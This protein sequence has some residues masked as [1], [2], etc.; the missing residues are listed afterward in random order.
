M[1]GPK[2]KLSSEQEHDLVT[3]YTA[4]ESINA[5]A[6]TTGLPNVTVS[7]TLKRRGVATRPE[8]LRPALPAEQRAQLVEECRQ[9]STLEQLAEKYDVAY[10]TAWRIVKEAGAGRGR[11]WRPRICALRED[12]FDVITPESARWMGFLFADGSL[13][14]DEWG[15]QPLA[16]NLGAKDRGHLE[17]LRKFLGS[18]HAITT[19]HLKERIIDHRYV[20]PPGTAYGYKV[21]SNRLANALI[22]RGMIKEKGPERTPT[23]ELEYMPAFWA[24]TIDGD[25][26]L[27]VGSNGWYHYPYIGL[28]GHIPLLKKF[29][30]FL[31]RYRLAELEI[32]P[33]ESGIYQLQT[34]GRTAK[35]IIR[36]L[37]DEKS[38]NAGLERK[39]VRAR[40]ILN[41]GP[42]TPYKEDPVVSIIEE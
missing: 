33:T 42:L 11:G 25:G 3:R 12:A 18:N 27:G 8:T 26:W 15:Q 21:R 2:R 30:A 14:R 34:S 38:A 13:P 31:E 10:M 23:A 5:I 4:G 6:K 37:Y 22:T 40:E 7:R 28:C 39:V 32:T 20:T 17:K 9:G 29:K 1:P 19:L 24:G 35:N 41:G 16:I 36:L